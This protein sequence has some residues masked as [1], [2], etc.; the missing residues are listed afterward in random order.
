MEADL[1]EKHLYKDAIDSA[2]SFNTRLL[3]ER[4]SRLPFLDTQT[5][6]AQVRE[7]L[8]GEGDIVTQKLAIS[9]FCLLIS[10]LF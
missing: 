5:N 7:L 4:Q 1:L 10:V 8:L 3:V 6:I 2:S 9:L